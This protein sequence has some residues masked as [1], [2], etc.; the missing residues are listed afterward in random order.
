MSNWTSKIPSFLWIPIIIGAIALF[1]GGSYAIF[2]GF[3]FV[4]GFSSI[5]LLVLGWFGFRICQRSEDLHKYG[6]LGTAAGITFFALMGMALDQPGNVL[7][8]KAIECVYCPE[9]SGLER[10]SVSRGLQGGGVQ[11]SQ[12][13]ECIDREGGEV[14]RRINMFELLAVRFGEYVVI[15]YLLLGVSRVYSRLYGP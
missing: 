10:E 13:F 14:V 11:V 9:N 12:K 3:T 6:A 1:I 8:N 5:L 4:E 2:Y 7:Y 15:G